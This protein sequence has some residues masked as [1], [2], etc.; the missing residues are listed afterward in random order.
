LYELY[1]LYLNR[2]TGFYLFF[3]TVMFGKSL[4]LKLSGIGAVLSPLPCPLPVVVNKSQAIARLNAQ[5]LFLIF[6]A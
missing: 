4:A 6:G 1:T 5:W 2:S 3:K